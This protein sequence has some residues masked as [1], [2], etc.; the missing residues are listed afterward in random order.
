[1]KILLMANRGIAPIVLLFLTA[2]VL[3]S[4][5]CGEASVVVHLPSLP[6]EAAT[7]HVSAALDGVLAN[8]VVALPVP[9][10]GDFSLVLR[11]PASAEGNLIVTAGIAD[12]DECL[13]LIGE[14]KVE[15]ESSYGV[16]LAVSPK[17]AAP[18]GAVRACDVKRPHLFAVA[19]LEISTSGRDRQGEVSPLRI[20]GWGFR[21][22]TTVSVDG[23]RFETKL[24]SS[25]EIEVE[26][27]RLPGRTG[28]VP[29]EVTNPDEVKAQETGALKVFLAPFGYK[30]TGIVSKLPDPVFNLAAADMNRD[31]RPD[32]VGLVEGA[33]AGEHLLSVYLNQDPQSLT[34]AKLGT[35]TRLPPQPDFPFFPHL[36]DV[37]G[38]GALDVIAVTQD[39]SLVLLNDGTGALAA[40]LPGPTSGSRS[41]VYADLDLDGD[42]D[43]VVGS[44]ELTV[45]RNKGGFSLEQ[46]QRLSI[47][48]RALSVAD[49]DGDRYPEVLIM[50]QGGGVR[51]LANQKGTL[52]QTSR[53]IGTIETC[54]TSVASPAV[55]DLDGTGLP[56]VLPGGS[57]EWLKRTGGTYEISR[58]PQSQGLDSCLER[59]YSADLNDDGLNDLITVQTFGFRV[60]YINPGADG[61]ASAKPIGGF[62]FI[63]AADIPTVADLNQDGRADLVF[64]GEVY[65][66]GEP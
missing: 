33:R 50:E 30:R 46:S 39:T 38:D 11:L 12:R 37:N 19:P 58:Y 27:I 32:L 66:L 29:I 45:F 4:T 24:I 5:G 43:L 44:S 49:L 36:V 55:A 8:E 17:L 22:G 20:R 48:A 10:G 41:F 56:D 6:A 13:L 64:S 31:G 21:K 34:F 9:G 47:P 65:L 28:S 52:S 53:L 16:T 25:L 14:D 42:A 51:V 18:P 62:G 63:V 26:R 23:L 54:G 7:L 2:W 35:G 57:A 60:V 3:A 61:L 1:M 15:I 40:P 59:I